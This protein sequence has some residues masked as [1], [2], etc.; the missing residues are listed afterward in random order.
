MYTPPLYHVTDPTRLHAFIR[1]N[2]FAVLF[3]T[4]DGRPLATHLPLLLEERGGKRFLIGHVAKANEHWRCAP[5]TALAVFHGPH[6][7]VSP[8]WYAE[9]GFVPT[10]DYC[11]VH[12]SG[13]LRLIDDPARAAAIIRELVRFF[14][15][16]QPAPWTIDPPDR[17]EKLMA[18][19]VAFEIEIERMDGQWK[20]SQNHSRERQTRVAAQLKHGDE[21]ARAI[22]ALIED[23]LRAPN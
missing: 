13:V 1:E 10:W 18:S 23:N 15:S 4:L 19:I 5:C 7:Y 6:A 14:E 22:S 17:F 2:S 12:A 9:P 16:P 20:L 3:S 11:A 21:N 8:T